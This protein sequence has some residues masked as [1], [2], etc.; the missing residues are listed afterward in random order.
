MTFNRIALALLIILGLTFYFLDRELFYY[1]KSD[2]KSYNF[3]PLNIVPDYPTRWGWGFTLRDD[4]GSNLTYSYPI[5][6]KNIFIS[7]VLKY[8]FNN[9]Q[10]VAI[11]ADSSGLMYSLKLTPP[12]HMGYDISGTLYLGDKTNEFKYKW[13]LIDGNNN[14]I[15]NL[16]LI[17][18]C[19]M[20]IF[21][22]LI[23]ILLYRSIRLIKNRK[24]NSN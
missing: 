23:L 21:S 3:L 2:F 4:I 7:K 24:I 22:V 12:P 1:G 8:G 14:Y 9:N 6:N 13:I 19:T 17:R 15:N 5:N 11:V 20:I 10:V 16:A 18:N